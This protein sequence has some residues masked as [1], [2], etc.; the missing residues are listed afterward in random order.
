MSDYGLL[1]YPF[2]E[3]PD[4]GETLV[5]AEGV[6]WLRMPLPFDLDHINLYLLDDGDGW[7]LVDT[8]LYTS[9]VR[10][11]WD[12]V[13][14]TELEGKP[15]KRII[16]THYHPDH[17]GCAGWLCE[18]FDIPLWMTFKEFHLARMIVSDQRPN[19]P[20]EYLRFFRRAGMP[21]QG[22]ELMKASGYGNF[23]KRVS[24]PPVGFHRLN[25]GDELEIG[26]RTWRILIGSGHS[27]EHACL[28]CED[29][30]LLISGD[31]LL[32]RI[33]AN[34]SVYPT[35]P[36]NN[37]LKPWIESQHMFK[38]LREDTLILP[39][40]N[41]PFKNIHQRADDVIAAHLR[42]L[43]ALQTHCAEE[44][45][46]AAEGFPV[47]YRRKLKGT[48]YVMALGE[49]LAHMHYLESLG[50]LERVDG[51]PIRFKTVG[52]LDESIVLGREKG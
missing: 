49:S 14:E 9:M 3:T 42:R 31:Q 18:R 48:D 30:A 39:A 27:P 19:P 32:P 1:D 25:E 52:E 16:A 29:E 22:V 2:D 34:V 38:T 36:M 4:F 51:M 46:S 15:I 41:T 21:E 40:H 26:G 28:Y 43:R 33:T 6:K 7:V 50:V 24:E 45:R 37:P 13:I 10:D 35:E 11:L 47:L 12:K 23:A 5:V 8:G 17:I 44:P 20:E